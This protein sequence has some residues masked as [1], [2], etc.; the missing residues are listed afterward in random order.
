MDEIGYER[1]QDFRRLFM[2]PG[3]THADVSYNLNGTIDW[4]C[5]YFKAPESWLDT[6][7]PP[8]RLVVKHWDYTT[9]APID[10]R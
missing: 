5:D 7:V 3:L 6:I 1:T 10:Y 9:G 2:M 8:D 4:R